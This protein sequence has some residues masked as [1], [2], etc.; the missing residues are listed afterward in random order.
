MGEAW[1][2]RAFCLAVVTGESPRKSHSK[3]L[4]VQAVFIE[5]GPMVVFFHLLLEIT[6]KT[7]WAILWCGK[8]IMHTNM[9]VRRMLWQSRRDT[10]HEKR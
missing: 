9:A 2:G 5:M 6:A 8:E 4:I 1:R 10:I 7:S 3:N